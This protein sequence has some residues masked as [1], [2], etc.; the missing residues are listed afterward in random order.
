MNE[1]KVLNGFDGQIGLPASKEQAHAW[2]EANRDFW[3]INPM[4]YDWKDDLSS[5]KFS[6]E[7]YREIDHRFLE[8]AI[9]YLLPSNKIFGYLMPYDQLADMDC[10]EI[11]VGCGTHAAL[12]AAGAKHFT[13]IDL[14]EYAVECTRRRFE[15][16]NLK[17]D[18]RRMDAEKME[19]GDA[20]FDFIWSWGVIHHSS[21]TSDILAEMRR[22]LRPGGRAV[23]MVYCRNLWNYYVVHGFAH[24]VLRGL[25]FKG[26]SVAEIMQL[27]TD[28]A[29]ARFY[30]QNEWREQAS[31]W[32]RVEKIEVFGQKSDLFPIP[33]GR[34]K[35]TILK[36]MPNTIGRFFTHQLGWGNFL[37]AHMVR[38]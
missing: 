25:L 4:R 29:L 33:A 16:F 13:G 26:C 36:R 10:L 3:E 8:Q 5:D 27:Q 38:D 2:Q 30:T 6:P 9:E 21:N 17:G 12:L 14:T 15:C 32:L 7:Y 24:G 20:S 18:I 31:S 35:Q 34:L 22:V 1:K 19:F 28:G 11:G 23:V 37:V